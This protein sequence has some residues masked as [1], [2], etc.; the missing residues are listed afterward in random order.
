[1]RLVVDGR[2][3]PPSMIAGMNRFRLPADARDVRL[4]SRSATPAHTHDDGSDERCLGVAVSR[5]VLDRRPIALDDPRLGSGWHGVEFDA[6]GRPCWR[7]TTGDAALA[8]T[9]PVELDIE[10]AMTARYWA[11]PP[12][13]ADAAAQPFHVDLA[14]ATFP[15]ASRLASFP[16]FRQ[17]GRGL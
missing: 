9:G 11:E 3:L 5:L 4:L 1:V 7:W 10:V 12:P 17:T 8:I 14:A 2:E 15:A 13:A 6:A 16:P